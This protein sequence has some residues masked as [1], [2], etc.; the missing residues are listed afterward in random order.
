M[1]MGYKVP[2]Y[3]GPVSPEK[4]KKTKT[5]YPTLDI[6]GEGALKFLKTHKVK[7]G[8]TFEAKATFKVTGMRQAA[9]TNGRID[10]YDNCVSLDTMSIDS[11]NE[12]NDEEMP[13]D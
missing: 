2:D 10:D 13:K 12:M 6:R 1:D 4:P 5:V 11:D 7:L 3:G 9:K 8:E